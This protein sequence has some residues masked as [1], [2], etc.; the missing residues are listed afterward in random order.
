MVSLMEGNVCSC[1]GK[2]AQMLRVPEDM[3]ALWIL[4]Y[5]QAKG[6]LMFGKFL[7]CFFMVLLMLTVCSVS[8]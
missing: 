8:L 4:G 3:N 6:I 1:E 2:G 5:L 7:C